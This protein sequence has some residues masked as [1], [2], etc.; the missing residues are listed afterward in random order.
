MKSRTKCL[1]CK[2]KKSYYA[3]T[4]MRCRNVN[5]KNNPNYGNHPIV[6]KE[7]RRKHS[8]SQM[9]KKNHEYI[10]GRYAK[11]YYCKDCNK[12]ISTGS[13]IYGKGRCPSCSQKDNYKKYGQRGQV[14]TT[15]AGYYKGIFMKSSWELKF[16]RFLTLSG[17]KWK[18]EPKIFNLGNITYT[19]DFYLSDS[20]CYIEIK[21]WWRDNGHQKVQRFI[22][23]FPNKLFML[24][25]K[26]DLINIGVL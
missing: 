19:P 9:G 7:T 25:R 14:G 24:L 12:E 6:S 16:A 15:K 11:Q 22:K 20:N 2:G 26:Q 13:G 17:I 1:K 10:D 18:Y 3:K 5:G 21:G 4:C 23:K 8:L